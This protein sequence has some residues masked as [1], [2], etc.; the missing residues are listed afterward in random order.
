MPVETVF[1]LAEAQQ[2]YITLRKNTQLEP[3]KCMTFGKLAVGT[4]L[5]SAQRFT[6]FYLAKHFVICNLLSF[7]LL[8]VLA[9]KLLFLCVA[10]LLWCLL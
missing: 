5:A 1:F 3:E 8:K 7:K 10:F 4:D 9:S 6:S 2:Y